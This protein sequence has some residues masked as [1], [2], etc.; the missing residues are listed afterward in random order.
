MTLSADSLIAKAVWNSAHGS[1][2][3]LMP[4]KHNVDTLS[5]TFGNCSTTNCLAGEFPSMIVWLTC[6]FASCTNARVVDFYEA[7]IRP[8]RPCGPLDTDKAAASKRVRAVYSMELLP[9]IFEQLHIQWQI[10]DTSKAR[11]I[12][13]ACRITLK[14]HHM[15]GLI[16]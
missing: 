6:P 7:M 10:L 12:L 4:P 1:L 5:G 11:V 14:R 9:E 8:V 2:I 15:I 16:Q 3:K 13:I